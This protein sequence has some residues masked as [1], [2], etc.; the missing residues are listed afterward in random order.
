M[1][2]NFWAN[3]NTLSIVSPN[4]ETMEQNQKITHFNA[5]IYP[6]HKIEIRIEGI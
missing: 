2:S 4:L 3:S 1:Y 5:C 6:I